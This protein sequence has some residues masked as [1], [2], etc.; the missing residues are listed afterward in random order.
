MRSRH[1]EFSEYHTSADNLQFVRPEAL[2]D[3]LSKCRSVFD[4]L[5][6]NR[7]YLN[8]NPK[9]EPQLGRRGL[10]SAQTNQESGALRQLALLWVLNL[11]DGEHSLLDIAERAKLPFAAVKE[12]AA[13]LAATDLLTPK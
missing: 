11:S 4:I 2:A 8:Q 1:G 13:S 5:E 10:Y 7:V 3:S 6:H 9:C 12:A